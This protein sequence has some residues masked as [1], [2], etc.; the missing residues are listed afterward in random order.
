MEP[1]HFDVLI[2]GAGLS[3]IGA[4]CHLSRE[5][6]TKRFAILDRREQVGGTWDLFHYPGIRSDSDMFSFGFDFHPWPGL[7]VL[8][9]GPSI[10]QYISDTAEEYSIKEHIHFGI[11]LSKANWDSEKKIWVID[12]INLKT[13]ERCSYSCRFLI[14]CTG[15]YDHH[16][17]YLPEFPGAEQ[18]QG[19][20]IHPQ[21][22]PEKLDYC[23]KTIVVIGSGATAVTLV[24]ALAEKAKHVTMLQRSPTYII[25]VPAFDKLSKK[26]LKI[27]PSS[28]V[29]KF[30]RWRNI[31][32]QRW[33]F[34]T[35]KRWPN[36][37]RKLFLRGVRKSL[38]QNFDMRHFTPSYQP[39][40]QRV[41]AVPDDNLF[42]AMRS[43]KTS[44]MTDEIESIGETGIQLKSGERITA[45]III[46]ATGLKLQVLGGMQ[47]YVD[48]NEVNIK[49]KLTYKAVLL[50][51]VPNMSWVF[52]YTNAPWT[53][54]ADISAKYICRLL[55]Y[56][57]QGNFDTCIAKDTEGCSENSSVMSSLNSGYVERGNNVL[58]RQGNKY[59]WRLLNNYEE[60][61]RILLKQPIEDGILTFTLRQA[62]EVTPSIKA[63]AHKTEE[64]MTS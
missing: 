25:S 23:N 42:K 6:P 31:K 11:E 41:C 4:A 2:I 24:P 51:G 34:K 38:P 22:W 13:G 43:G 47:L 8:A 52:G 33:L 27:L 1:L 15:Y 10:Q 9:D 55:N 29:F 56:M 40:D 59:P 14:S 60:D 39:W 30:A 28:W 37:M 17:G 18:F 62:P 63:S 26:L 19:D 35:S 20:Y 3:G 49:E 54:K 36:F 12:G 5:C 46:T 57:D 45:D 32:I 7:K 48:G 21:H 53:L 16:Q 50:E 44:V 64:T 61:S 58:P